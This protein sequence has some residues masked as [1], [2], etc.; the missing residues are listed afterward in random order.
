MT[1]NRLISIEALRFIFMLVIAVW[2]FSRINPFT[3]GYIAVDFFFILSGFLLYGSYVRHKYDALQYTI[4]KLKRFYPEYFIVFVVGF[5]LKLS[6][7][8]RDGDAVSVLLNAMSE[9]LLVHS[10]G[11][12]GGSINPAS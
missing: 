7:M 6:I 9:G 3:H 10:V 4:A 11:V 2:H 1:N 8:L 5:L 12:F